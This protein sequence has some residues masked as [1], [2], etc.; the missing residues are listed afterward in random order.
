VVLRHVVS[1]PREWFDAYVAAE[2]NVTVTVDGN[3]YIEGLMWP[4]IG[5]NLPGAKAPGYGP[6]AL[7]PRIPA[8]QATGETVSPGSLQ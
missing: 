1:P 8:A 3:A 5:D 7:P 4:T 2:R 6:W